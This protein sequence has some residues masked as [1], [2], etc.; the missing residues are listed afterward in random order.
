M[1]NIL[2]YYRYCR[3]GGVQTVTHFLANAFQTLGHSCA[4]FYLE[5]D[6]ALA[7]EQ[8]D[9]SV[10]LVVANAS[11]RTTSKDSLVRLL[12]DYQP[13]VIINQGGHDYIAT[14]LLVQVTEGKIPFISIYHSMPGFALNLYKREFSL[15]GFILEFKH[16][17]DRF[18]AGQAMR[19][20]Y[21]NSKYFALLSESF[22]PLFKS[23]AQLNNYDK[24]S[25][26]PNPITISLPKEGDL[27]Y[28][29]KEVIY[30]G[31]LSQV[32]RI[33]RILRIWSNIERQYP[34]WK[35]T[36]VGD[37]ECRVKLETLAQNFN[38][39]R[40][41]FEGF[42]N[43][44]TYYQRASILLLTS[45]HEG[46]PLVLAEAMVHR[47]VPI[48]YASYSAVYDIIE[49]Q[50]DGIIVKPQEREDFIIERFVSELK[51]LMDFPKHLD[52]LRNQAYDKS[53]KYSEKAII[54]IWKQLFSSLAK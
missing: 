23:Y 47:V 25:V 3:V 32:K 18:R 52:F 33:D 31:R 34:D 19:Y 37:G 5:G 21:N 44:K 11:N 1:M 22:V 40:V 13:D 7:Q 20:I 8:L 14:K 39:N 26:I 43:P 46:F 50:R 48:V 30:V 35:L 54:G 9:S 53:H 6:P 29:E 17:I 42:K 4:V 27:Q 38:L 16:R 41:N 45:D 10:S 28:K 15:K 24:L 49:H 36:I 12:K 2:F 51:D